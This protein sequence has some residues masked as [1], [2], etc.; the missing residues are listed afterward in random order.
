MSSTLDGYSADERG[1]Y[2]WS[3]PTD[4]VVA[5]LSADIES[6]STY[7]YGR[8]MYEAMAGWETDPRYAAQSAEL[9]RFAETWTQADKVVFSSALDHIWTTRTRL[10]RELTVDVLTRLKDEASGDLTIEGP[11]L[12]K[13]ALKLGL[14]DIVE[15]LLW[16]VTI[17]GGTS[18]LPTKF[19]MK[20]SLIRERRFDN[21]TV[22]VRYAVDR[23]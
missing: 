11:T 1:D 13:A 9:A 18:V 4:D 14:V 21:G 7:L 2:S 12:A 10:E 20:L 17:G 22:Q 15:F 23:S 19:S 16:P 5:A 3:V 6:V 8:R